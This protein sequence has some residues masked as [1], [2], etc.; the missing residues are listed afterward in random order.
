MNDKFYKFKE[1]NIILYEKKLRS[2]I[3]LF[4]GESWSQNG[5]DSR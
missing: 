2:L 5:D 4:E 1:R 3:N